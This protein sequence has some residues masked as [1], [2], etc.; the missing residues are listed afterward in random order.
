MKKQSKSLLGLLIGVIVLIGCMPAGPCMAKN[1]STQI[2]IEIG[3]KTFKATL[4]NNKTSRALLKKFPLSCKMSE[5]NGNEKYKYLSYELPTNKKKV[6]RIKAGDIMLYGSDC[7]VVFY[8]SHKTSYEYTKVGHI[9]NTR[10]LKKAVGKGK[11]KM[12]FTRIREQSNPNTTQESDSTE[13]PKP[14]PDVT[15]Q[16]TVTPDDTENTLKPVEDEN[17][18]ETNPTTAPNQQANKKLMIKIGDKKV[19]VSWE[20]NE[21][22]GALMDMCKDSPL[23][24]QMSMYGGFE[25]VGSLGTNLPRNDSQTTTSSGDI[26]LYSGNQIVVF[27]GRNSWSYTRLGHITDQDHEGMAEL[28]SQGDVTITISVE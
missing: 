11:V 2:N 9:N 4:Y 27:Y 20:E 13:M 10:G 12:K 6:K 15:V 24:I 1:N 19:D 23:E 5:L 14:S 16:P 8:K 17:P 25:Q 26:V 22:V 28:L 3:K 7:L 21:S 18:N